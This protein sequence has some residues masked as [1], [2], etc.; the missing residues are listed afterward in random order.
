MEGP[1][2]EDLIG[3]TW[4]LQETPLSQP[5]APSPQAP[6]P[7][8]AV[9]RTA[10]QPQPCSPPGFLAGLQGTEEENWFGPLRQELSRFIDVT[11]Q[12]NPGSQGW[13]KALEHAEELRKHLE[14]CL[15]P[16]RFSRY[17]ST[18]PFNHPLVILILPKQLQQQNAGNE[19]IPLK[20]KTTYKFRTEL[21]FPAHQPASLT[22]S[23][24]PDVTE[25]FPFDCMLDG[26]RNTPTT[27]RL[28][29][30]FRICFDVKAGTPSPTA[31][32]TANRYCSLVVAEGNETVLFT[33][34]F[35]VY[36]SAG[37][38]KEMKRRKSNITK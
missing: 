21:S 27:R 24:Q 16:P 36:S 22:I 31:T 6:E 12:H 37:Y 32:S 4:P 9:T 34:R 2:Q 8:P 17:H 18:I 35:A 15:T 11:S 33:V 20:T 14:T 28:G 30:E 1:G 7:G 26:F 29:E 25:S 38:K 23:W 5:P 10:A 13:R 3:T 19:P